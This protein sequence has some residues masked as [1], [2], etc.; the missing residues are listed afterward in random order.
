MLLDSQEKSRFIAWLDC[1][2][3]S[4]EAL[5]PQIE[6]LGIKPLADK[7]KLELMACTIVRKMLSDSEQ[8]SIKG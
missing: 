1:Q 2:I 7:N 8:Q 4:C 6:K 3:T 5:S